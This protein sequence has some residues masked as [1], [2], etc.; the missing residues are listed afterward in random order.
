MGA[1]LNK[2]LV[3][4]TIAGRLERVTE[5]LDRGAAIDRLHRDGF[6]PLMR[7][8]Y[9]GHAALVRLLLSRG[10]NPNGQAL[11]GASALFWACVRGHEAIVDQLLSAEANV[12]AGRRSDGDDREGCSPLNAA[13]GNGHLRIAKKLVEAGASLDHHFLGRDIARYA[14]WCG[15]KEFVSYLKR[16]TRR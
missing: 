15:A 8:A 3:R 12:N 7:A 6:T 10:A 11:D 5:L 9:R 16:P 4:E 13:I 14:E 2:Q 1:F